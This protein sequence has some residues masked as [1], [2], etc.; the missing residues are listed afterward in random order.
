MTSLKEK[1]IR[2]MHGLVGHVERDNTL[3][4]LKERY[5]WLQLEKNVTTVVKS[6]PV[7]QVAK[8]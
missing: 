6:C 4:S 2:D 3:A 1:V 5:C 7:C 8:G